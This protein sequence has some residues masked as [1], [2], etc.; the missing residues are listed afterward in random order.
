MQAISG[1]ALENFLGAKIIADAEFIEANVQIDYTYNPNGEPWTI[2]HWGDLDTPNYSG[3]GNPTIRAKWQQVVLIDSYED[4]AA[5]SATNQ[6]YKFPDV[7]TGHPYVAIRVEDPVVDTTASIITKNSGG[8]FYLVGDPVGFGNSNNKDITINKNL[9]DGIYRDWSPGEITTIPEEASLFSV[10]PNDFEGGAL[11]IAGDAKILK[12][13]GGI[14]APGGVFVWGA[15]RDAGDPLDGGAL[16]FTKGGTPLKAWTARLNGAKF[17]GD[18]SL[19]GSIHNTFSQSAFFGGR[20]KITASAAFASA[21]FMGHALFNSP[22]VFNSG[23]EPKTIFFWDSVTFADDATLNAGTSFVKTGDTAPY[24]GK[25]VMNTF[26]K[27]IYGLTS[28]EIADADLR[29]GDALNSTAFLKD[30]VIRAGSQATELNLVYT[31]PEVTTRTSTELGGSFTFFKK[32]RFDGDLVLG[33]D[34]KEVFLLGDTEFKGLVSG[35]A[36]V[37]DISAGGAISFNGGVSIPAGSVGNIKTSGVPNSGGNFIIGGPVELQYGTFSIPVIISNGGLTLAHGTF[38]ADVEITGNA[39]LNKTVT[40][41][42]ALNITGNLV[43]AVDATVTI[44]GTLSVNGDATLPGGHQAGD[45]VRTTITGAANFGEASSFGGTVALGNVTLANGANF[46]AGGVVASLTVNAGSVTAANN[47]LV[48]GATP[49]YTLPAGGTIDLPADGGGVFS[50]SGRLFSLAGGVGTLIGDVVLNPNTQLHLGT[51]GLFLAGGSNSNLKHGTNP[52]SGLVF[53]VGAGT[54]VKIEATGLTAYGNNAV[55]LTFGANG[56]LN[57]PGAELDVANMGGSYTLNKTVIDLTDYGKIT[58]LGT[59]SVLGMTNGGNVKTGDN[60]AGGSASTTAEGF[61][62]SYLALNGVDAA[63]YIGAGTTDSDVR[64]ASGSFTAEGAGTASGS[65]NTNY[66]VK[67]Y[68]FA[69]SLTNLAVSTAGGM[70]TNSLGIGTEA[71]A[72][73]DQQ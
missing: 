52:S 57:I 15:L 65:M 29:P 54:A 31:E 5:Y 68:V 47:A 16:G 40:F 69:G 17:G 46:E 70:K 26:Y 48:L 28:D 60:N 35:S 56:E 58:L 27:G 73:F 3:T 62:L 9:P 45:G 21:T 25:K 12:N 20:A 41:S 33:S 18:V 36:A 8:V 7:T 11:V 6:G 34:I 30:K 37:I 64:I 61:P 53:T 44:T 38:D 51:A 55:T 22:V 42:K 49:T 1:I 66:I 13:G 32:V 43:G 10:Y 19:N 71:I 2:E 59:H 4:F 50:Y 72:V 67:G 24:S 23:K 14:N 39:A 63:G